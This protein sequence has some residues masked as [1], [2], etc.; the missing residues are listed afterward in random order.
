MTILQKNTNS[1]VLRLPN[2]K[3][4]P[5]K[6]PK[7]ES[8]KD[9][10]SLNEDKTLNDFIISKCRFFI[11]VTELESHLKNKVY[12]SM[13]VIDQDPGLNKLPQ[14]KT[15]QGNPKAW[16]LFQK[17]E[18]KD[19]RL[20]RAKKLRLTRNAQK[21]LNKLNPQEWTGLEG[22]FSIQKHFYA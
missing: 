2:G 21:A 7:I 3:L 4:I 16:L 14:E 10:P 9:L 15:W 22:I 5:I 19:I 6:L 18:Q 13:E 12:P 20:K 17:R 1:K 8:N 11:T